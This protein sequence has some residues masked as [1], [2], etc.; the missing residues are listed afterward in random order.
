MTTITHKIVKDAF[1]MQ[2][3]HAEIE[4]IY[5]LGQKAVVGYKQR[6]GGTYLHKDVACND[7]LRSKA[8]Y[9]YT[10]DNDEHYKCWVTEDYPSFPLGKYVWEVT[11]DEWVT[12]D[13]PPARTSGFG[14]NEGICNKHLKAFCGELE[15]KGVVKTLEG[16]SSQDFFFKDYGDELLFGHMTSWRGVFEIRFGEEDGKF[17]FKLPEP[18]T[19]DEVKALWVNQAA[20]R[21]ILPD[22][23]K[24]PSKKVEVSF[25]DSFSSGFLESGSNKNVISHFKGYRFW[26]C[27]D[28]KRFFLRVTSMSTDWRETTVITLMVE[29]SDER[30]DYIN[31][32]G[33]YKAFYPEP[34]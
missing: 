28:P 22:D 24:V 31:K 10:Y 17:L 30:L 33:G 14:K 15:V 5:T 20:L 2:T 8:L 23:K 19:P 9:E 1:L 13:L 26:D 18:F 12:L 3:N 29:I 6:C 4:H 27:N 11:S 25:T 16:K 34:H 7:K 21:K 32:N